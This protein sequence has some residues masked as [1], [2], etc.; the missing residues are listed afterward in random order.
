M[1]ERIVS[2]L[3]RLA[4]AR[5]MAPNVGLNCIMWAE[6]LAEQWTLGAIHRAVR[7]DGNNN[8]LRLCGA[9]PS[10]PF[11]WFRSDL[12]L[13]QHWEASRSVGLAEFASK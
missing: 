8:A 5:P 3:P 13:T 1:S 2:K 9:A 4:L 6:R 12:R 11:R 7:P 10:S